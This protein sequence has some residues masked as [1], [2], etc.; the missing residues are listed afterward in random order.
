MQVIKIYISC[1]I[2]Y[3]SRQLIKKQKTLYSF[4]SKMTKIFCTVALL[5]VIVLYIDAAIKMELI[6]KSATVYR[7]TLKNIY[8]ISYIHQTT[9]LTSIFT[10]GMACDTF[11][12]GCML[13][14]CA[15]IELLKYTIGQISFLS[16]NL[17]Y[18]AIVRCVDHHNNIFR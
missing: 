13:Q 9:A 18:S 10:F 5:V 16:E 6:L 2:Y 14:L 4:F 15:Q 11:V 3:Y 17:Q 8:W 1:Y 7:V 12:A